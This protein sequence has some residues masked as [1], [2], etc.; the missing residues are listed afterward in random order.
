MKI[1]NIEINGKVVLA[2]MAGICNEAFREICKENGADLIYSEMVSDKAIV[3]QN[4]KSL[5]MTQVSDKEHPIALQIFGSNLDTFV[6]AAQY[7]D[8]NSAC[9][10]I[11]INMGCPVP[12]VAISCQAGAALMKSPEKIYEIVKKI[13]ESVSKPVTIKIRLGWDEN[14]INCVEVAKIAEKAGAKAISVHAR[15]RSQQYTGKAR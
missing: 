1:G 11:D 13:S 5:K 2:P 12:K 15:T 4:P 14:S 3:F 9:D 10:I 7:A 6:Q 8:K